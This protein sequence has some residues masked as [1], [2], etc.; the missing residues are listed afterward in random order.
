VKTEF[1]ILHT[2]D[3]V[4]RSTQLYDEE[5]YAIYTFCNLGTPQPTNFLGVKDQFIYSANA[6]CAV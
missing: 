1:K 6:T 2:R 5:S 4:V 3:N